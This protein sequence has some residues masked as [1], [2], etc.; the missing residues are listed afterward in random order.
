MLIC[1]F[2]RNH[3]ITRLISFAKKVQIR[4]KLFLYTDPAIV[5]KTRI[6]GS[7]Q[8]ELSGRGPG[9]VQVL[10][11]GSSAEAQRFLLSWVLDAILDLNKSNSGEYKKQNKR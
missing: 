8:Q 4:D 7:V 11:R 10:M 9:V 2:S 3:S 5:D 6:N 1:S